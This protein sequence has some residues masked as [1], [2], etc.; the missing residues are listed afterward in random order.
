MDNENNNIT[1]KTTTNKKTIT[2]RQKPK[3]VPNNRLYVPAQ[4]RAT[5]K[6]IYQKQPDTLC[7]TC[8]HCTC[9]DSPDFEPLSQTLPDGRVSHQR[10]C[11]WASEYKPVPGWTAERHDIKTT[12][13]IYEE[14]YF[15]TACPYYKPDLEGQIAA[16]SREK[17]RKLI[18]LPYRFIDTH[19]K[20]SIRIGVEYVKAIKR[21]HTE[22][23]KE[24]TR[25]DKFKLREAVIKRHKFFAQCDVESLDELRELSPDGKLSYIDQQ[26][27]NNAKF[28]IEACDEALKALKRVERNGFA[29]TTFL[30]EA[31]M[32]RAYHKGQNGKQTKQVA[33]QPRP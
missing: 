3:T 25:E 14:S 31:F 11:P 4:Q 21:L 23:A 20:L 33:Q 18:C 27:Y 24:L 6:A 32:Q 13:D 5:T 8:E 29:P 17:M 30:S 16:L 12:Q 28:D 26:D 9:T 19:K 1:D 10:V 7:Y 22:T 15:V 2:R